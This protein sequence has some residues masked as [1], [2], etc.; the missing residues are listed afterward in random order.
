MYWIAIY[1]HGRRHYESLK[2]KD[3]TTALYLKS[4]L[5][6][7]A[8][9]GKYVQYDINP[10][11]SKILDEYSASTQHHK[12][13]KTIQN[14]VSRIR[15]FLSWSNVQTINHISEKALQDYLTHR[16][17]DDGCALT[18][19]NRYISSIKAWLNFAVRRRYVYE[20][21]LRSFAKYRPP[22]NPP[23]FLSREDVKKILNAAAET[24]LYFPILMALYTGMRRK[25]IFCLEWHDVD[26]DRNTI[27]VRNKDGFITKSKKSR[28]IPLHAHLKDTLLP[29][30]ATS[31]RC[32]NITNHKKIFRKI[33][34]AAGIRH[35]GFHDFRHTFASHLV[36]SG[37]D[38]YTV[39]QILG[40]SS[41]R[42]TQVYSH[43]TRDHMQTAIER[44]AF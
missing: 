3:R 22:E 29:T 37:V 38:L 32:F 19:A 43:L 1:R 13:P 21:P 20:N 6:K 9:E 18:S 10:S 40:H 30:R 8:A 17:N 34:A 25:E 24:I 7:E 35:I 4:K 41:I 2:T 28:T 39:S 16:I 23:R 44:L 14:D 27:T 33:N 42:V 5:E 15:D 26:F 36:M 31:G 11:C 12:L